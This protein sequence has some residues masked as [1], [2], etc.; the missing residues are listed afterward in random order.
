MNDKTPA[1]LAQCLISARRHGAAV[2]AQGWEGTLYDAEQAY[3]VQREVGTALGWFDANVPMFWK[4]GGP[5]RTALL[6]HSPLAPPRVR[7]SPADFADLTLHG[8]GIEAEIALRLGTSVTPAMAATLTPENAA[9]MVE[10]MTV[11]I[12]VVDSRW[13]QAQQAPALLRLADF[14]SHGALALGEWLPYAARDWPAQRCEVHIGMQPPVVRTGTL[15]LGEPAWLLPTWLR[16]L[17]RHGDTVPAG[18]VVTTGSW[19]GVLPARRGDA[20]SVEFPG[21]GVTRLQL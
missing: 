3:A 20:V 6:T 12:E 11:S 13:Q 14:Q 19:V 4:S 8:P 7:S 18:A 1:A 16:H 2:S 5:S 21:I 10:A 15:P 9:A 17:T